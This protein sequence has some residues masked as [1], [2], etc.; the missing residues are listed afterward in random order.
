MQNAVCEPQ[1]IVIPARSKVKNN[2]SQRQL[3]VAAYCRVSTDEDEQ[4]TSFE[5]Q[6]S[7]YTEKINSS[8]GWRMAGIFADEGITGTVD[9][10]R[11][12]FLK[13]IRLCRNRKIDLILTKSISRFA[14]NTV[15]CLKYVREL[16]SLGIGVIFEKE[17]IDTMRIDS[18]MLL[19][20]MS[21]FAQ[22]ESESISK[23]VSWGIR[24]S[25]KSG[26]VSINYKFMLGYRK[27]ADGKP[28][29]VPDEAEIVKEI[30]RKYL[31]GCS[32]NQ[33][34]DYLNGMGITTKAGK[35][36]YDITVSNIL[37]NEKYTGDAILQK[38]YVLDCISKKRCVNNGELPKYLVKGHHEAIISHSEFDR[39]QA[40]MARRKSKRK[41]AE[42]LTKTENGKYSAKFALSELLICGECGTPYR[43]VTWT[44]KGFKEI[45]WRCV[46]RL[47]YGKKYCHNSPTI[48]EETLHRAI[49]ESINNFCE[50]QSEVSETLRE[51]LTE[52]LDPTLNGSVKA[53]QERISELSRNIDE[54][55]KLAAGGDTEQSMVDIQKFSN[56]MTALREFIEFEKAKQSAAEKD[57]RQ[58]ETVLDMLEKENFRL[59]EYDDVAVR[60]L[61]EYIKVID[62]N[63][64]LICFKG[65]FEVR[66]ELN[67][68]N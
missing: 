23:N 45:K 56:E 53:A 11:P 25:F 41:I 12:E 44:A 21:S 16:K 59:T 26:K 7:Y 4:E 42:K 10:K 14:R 46:S 8:A 39:V 40:E 15:D 22:A 43:R 35:K 36:W 66:K 31:D 33:I 30:F 64:L 67:I 65:G 55:I 34:A 5:A 57:N 19:T 1:V 52:V 54:L 49:V 37:T 13:M 2:I 62:K 3:N 17:N 60:H 61:I 6:I 28:E 48:A 18:E 58:L 24:Q 32:Q 29:I 63:T 20:V 47:Q 50:V 38:T 9:T 51:S 27:G 68:G